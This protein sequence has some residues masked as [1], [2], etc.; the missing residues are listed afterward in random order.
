[1]TVLDP[2]AL[3]STDELQKRAGYKIAFDEHMAAEFQEY[4]ECHADALDAVSDHEPELDALPRLCALAT[5]IRDAVLSREGFRVVRGIDRYFGDERVWRLFQVCLGSALGEVLT[6]Y[7]KLYEV[8]D[9][10][11]DYVHEAVPVSMTKERTGF[12]TDSSNKSVVPDFVGLLCERVSESGGDSM[13]ANVRAIRDRLAAE[14]PELL[15]VLESDF[16]R[17]VVTP[18]ADKS[19][20]AVRENRFPVFGPSDRP[21]GLTFRYMRFWIERGQERV[22][23]PLTEE[24]CRAFDRLDELLNDPQHHVQFRLEPS[25]ILWVDN[26]SLAHDRSAY[27]DGGRGR[28]LHRMWVSMPSVSTSSAAR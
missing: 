6:V 3:W 22:G 16:V 14:E 15:R 26:R 23:T 18:N 1:M 21:C 12:H 20:E 9:R 2:V 25:D 10:G 28:L 11:N 17:D 4:L 7:G 8:R 24:Q 19:V 5:Q 13:V 27:V